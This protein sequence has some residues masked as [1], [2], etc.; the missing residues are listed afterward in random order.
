MKFVF[1]S[2]CETV[3]FAIDWSIWK[4]GVNYKKNCAFVHKRAPRC[5]KITVM[6]IL[7][8]KYS[9]NNSLLQFVLGPLVEQTRIASSR[10]SR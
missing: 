9:N 1:K 10:Q 5:C 2:D 7:M 3:D 6:I 8:T 4:H